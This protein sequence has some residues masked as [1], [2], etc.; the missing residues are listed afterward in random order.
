MADPLGL[1]GTNTHN[2]EPF[3]VAA[4]E[5]H[6]ANMSPPPSGELLTG[7]RYR[8]GIGAIFPSSMSVF[9]KDPQYAEALG[10]QG[11]TR[12][13]ITLPAASGAL[14]G[15][16]VAAAATSPAVLSAGYAAYNSPIG[17][18]VKEVS[19]NVILE[20][21]LNMSDPQI[22]RPDAK[23]LADQDLRN[24]TAQMERDTRPRVR[25]PDILICRR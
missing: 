12:N 7:S 17:Q 1:F 5:A 21:V 8:P 20:S 25:V 19:Q 13:D 9:A 16:M 24:R 22:D 3:G 23:D 10:Y 15:P 2:L 11:A 6:G 18:C 14:G 4:R